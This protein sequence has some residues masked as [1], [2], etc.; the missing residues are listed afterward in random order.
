MEI[1]A[2][3][4]LIRSQHI[5]TLCGHNVEILNAKHQLI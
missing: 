1:I 3:C 4:S 5:N 2:D